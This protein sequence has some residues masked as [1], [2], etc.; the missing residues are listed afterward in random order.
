MINMQKIA[1]LYVAMVLVGCTSP[2]KSDDPLTRLGA[3]E[4]VSSEDEL[5]LIAMNLGLRVGGR[6]G[7]YRDAALYS[8][9]YSEDVRVAAVNRITDPMPAQMRILERW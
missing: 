8:E 1:F 7:S 4:R 6:S 5:F 3:V 2:L 9:H